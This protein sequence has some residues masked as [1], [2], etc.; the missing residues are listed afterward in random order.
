MDKYSRLPSAA[1]VIGAFRVTQIHKNRHLPKFPILHYTKFVKKQTPVQ[2][3]KL[4]RFCYIQHHID[5]RGVKVVV[6]HA[7][8]P[9]V[10]HHSHI[11]LEQD[12]GLCL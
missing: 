1:V 8:F 4:V 5:H 2:Q 3:F 9:R 11:N 10:P 6:C 12:T 7:K